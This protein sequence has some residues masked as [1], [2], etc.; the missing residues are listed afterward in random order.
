MPDFIISLSDTSAGLSQAGGK[1]ASLARLAAAGL[2]VPDGFHVTTAAYEQFVAYNQLEAE[3]SNALAAT[4][5]AQPVTL[6]AAARRIRAA[7]EA[8]QMPD[9]IAA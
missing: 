6:E 7:F 4:D 2:P 3:I 8:S 9:A 1:G 5:P